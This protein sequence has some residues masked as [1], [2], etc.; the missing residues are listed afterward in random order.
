MVNQDV[1]RERE[2]RQYLQLDQTFSAILSPAVD[3][4]RPSKTLVAHALSSPDT[5][6]TAFAQLCAIRLNA[7]RAMIR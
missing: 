2:V 3:P 4:I 7:Q 5:T 6:L 1:L